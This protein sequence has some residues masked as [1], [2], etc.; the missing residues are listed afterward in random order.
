MNSEMDGVNYVILGIG[1]NVNHDREDFPPR[2]RS[3]ATSVLLQTGQKANRPEL[4]RRFLFEFE[5]SYFNF[6]RYG[7][8]FLGPELIRRS[9]VLGKKIIVT[10]GKK[11][12]SGEAVGFDENGALRMKIGDEV[13][14]IS[15]GEV[16]LKRR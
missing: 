9:A 11:K 15:G 13:R 6:Q 8:R 14:S 16:T 5:K 12:I 10:L 7:L 1:I 2:L 3:G 4:L